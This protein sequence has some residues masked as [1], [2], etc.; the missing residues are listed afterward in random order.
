VICS[1]GPTDAKHIIIGAH[2]DVCGQQPGADDNGTGVTG[3]LE[4]VRM[5]KGQ[6]LHYRIDLVAY[7]ITDTAFYRNANYHEKTDTMETLDLF[8]M[9]KV[10]DGVYKSVLAL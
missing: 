9:S 5:L 6:K 1:F 10:I 8:R 3:L 4:L 2:Y 7:M